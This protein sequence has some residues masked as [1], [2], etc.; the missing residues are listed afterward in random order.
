M[1][2]IYPYIISITENYLKYKDHTKPI[3]Y[4]RFNFTVVSDFYLF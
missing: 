4:V 3:S 2:I 1:Y